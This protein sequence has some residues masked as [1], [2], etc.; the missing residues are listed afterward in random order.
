[1]PDIDGNWIDITSFCTAIAYA[2][3]N[4]IRRRPH[5][6]ISRATSIDLA[7]GTSIFP[8]LVLGFSFLSTKLLNELLHANKLILSVAGLCALLAMLEDDF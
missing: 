6:L 7:N 1:M 8:L 2:V 5:K 3:F 4:S